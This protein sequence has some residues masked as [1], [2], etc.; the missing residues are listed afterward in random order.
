MFRTL[1]KVVDFPILKDV[2]RL[3]NS[4]GKKAGQTGEKLVAAGRQ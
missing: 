1:P 4:L 2:S 3:A